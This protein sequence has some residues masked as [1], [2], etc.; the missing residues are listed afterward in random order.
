MNKP[1]SLSDIPRSLARLLVRI[2]LM[3][4][5]DGYTQKEIGEQLGLS[6]IKVNR[7]LQQAKE[8]GIVEININ[9]PPDVYANLE[10]ALCHTY[11]VRD[12]VV[13]SEAEP[14]EMLYQALAQGAAEWLSDRLEDGLVVGIGQGRTLSTIPQVFAIDKPVDCTFAEIVGGANSRPGG[15]ANYNIIS[16]MAELVGGRA[17]YVYAPTIVSSKAIRDTFL[18]ETSIANALDLARRADIV[19][20]SVGPVDRTALL[21][22]HGFLDDDDLARLCALGAVGDTLSQYFDRSGQRVQHPI[23]DQVVGLSLDDLRQAAYSVVVAGGSEKVEVL[24]AAMR[25]RLLN[26]LV[27]DYVTATALLK[28]EA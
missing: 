4:Y 21:Y 13:V 24:R 11:G 14:G 28:G 17:S 10:Q 16:K 23:C 20:H 25:G 6:R 19:L 8:L 5:G 18:H 12:A 15:F 26:V 27:T 3:Y 22:I 7:L 2:A 1:D 9:T